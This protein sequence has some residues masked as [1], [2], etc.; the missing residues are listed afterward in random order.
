M[1]IMNYLLRETIDRQKES[2]IVL[3]WTDADLLRE[4]IK[5]RIS[6]NLEKNDDL[7]F[8]EYWRKICVSHINGEET[9]QFLID[10]S[11]M[12]PRFLINL[13]NQCKSF[14]INYNHSKINEEDIY[15]RLQFLFNGFTN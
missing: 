12:R 10:R 6:S 1:M 4:V 14:A 11:L 13:I 2:K 8:D 9:S 3:D 7:S 5:L 15:K